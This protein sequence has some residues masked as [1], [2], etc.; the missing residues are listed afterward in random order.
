MVPAD[1]GRVSAMS[2]VALAVMAASLPAGSAEA[3]RDTRGSI[4]AKATP[5][6]AIITSDW[7][8]GRSE[9]PASTAIDSFMA[10]DESLVLWADQFSSVLRSPANDQ[11]L[12]EGI[13]AGLELVEP[14]ATASPL[15]ELDPATTAMEPG[16][17]SG[18][19]S[20]TFLRLEEAGVAG[21]VS[22]I[23]EPSVW[24]LMLLGVPALLRTS[25]RRRQPTR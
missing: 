8:S 21:R 16:G 9:P 23:P 1:W 2:T 11:A 5:L 3:E 7:T 19:A 17:F 15:Y 18:T 13:L 6:S 22:A 20:A 12:I 10:T 4:R 24:L 14:L 25:Y